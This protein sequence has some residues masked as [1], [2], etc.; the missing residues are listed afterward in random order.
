MHKAKWTDNACVTNTLVCFITLLLALAFVGLLGLLVMGCGQA[1]S[2]TEGKTTVAAAP[3]A[4]FTTQCSCDC[5]LPGSGNV[6]DEREFSAES[7]G[8]LTRIVQ[9]AKA[10]SN[11]GLYPTQCAA[12]CQ[13]AQCGNW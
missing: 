11:C 1:P 9:V 8:E 13:S 7:C 6:H 12:S 5:Y 4:A 3:K 2:P 10:N